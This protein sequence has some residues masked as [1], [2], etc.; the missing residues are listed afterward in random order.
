MRAVE[1]RH[2]TWA[3]RCS[4]GSGWPQRA[5]A[6][7]CPW[8]GR[9][10]AG[11]QASACAPGKVQHVLHPGSMNAA[12]QP[13][14]ARLAAHRA[15]ATTDAPARAAAAAPRPPT[16]PAAW[17]GRRQRR[18]PRRAAGQ[19]HTAGPA[20]GHLH[21]GQPGGSQPASPVTPAHRPG[22]HAMPSSGGACVHRPMNSSRGCQA[23][24]GCPASSQTVDSWRQAGPQASRAAGRA[25]ASGTQARAQSLGA[26]EGM[27]GVVPAAP[28]SRLHFSWASPHS[29]VCLPLD[30]GQEG[31]PGQQ[32]VLVRVKPGFH[33]LAGCP[34]TAEHCQLCRG[35]APADAG[36]ACSSPRRCVAQRTRLSC[37]HAESGAADVGA[38]LQRL[39]ERRCAGCAA[40]SPGRAGALVSWCIG[41]RCCCSLGDIDACAELLVLDLVRLL[42]EAS[43]PGASLVQVRL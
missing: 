17:P 33:R 34:C 8:Q 40:R 5:P 6:A 13:A 42:V 27:E 21:A 1:Q 7:G 24:T 19:R 16:G 14:P 39:E 31:R 22:T 29:L 36:Q 25:L 41:E 26:A 15:P 35:S 4:A 23:I 28:G 43:E 10:P 3:H 38:S 12:A 2:D 32:R 30:Q 20:S 18:A 37:W 11:Q 9:A